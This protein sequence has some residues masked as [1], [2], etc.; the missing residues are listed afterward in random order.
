MIPTAEEIQ[1]AFT[2]MKNMKI[3]LF[4]AEEDALKARAELKRREAS[5][6]LSGAINGKNAE[7]RDAQLNEGCQAEIA[8][9]EKIEAEKR[10]TQLSYELA[11]MTVD[12]LKW[13]IRAESGRL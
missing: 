9:L 13:I 4:H 6:M 8:A 1:I 5:L 11:C 10:A 3:S 12:S 2:D 7:T